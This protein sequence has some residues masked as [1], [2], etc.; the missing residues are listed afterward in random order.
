MRFFPEHVADA[1]F[2]AHEHLFSKEYDRPET[3]LHTGAFSAV[4]VTPGDDFVLKATVCPVNAAYLLKL[5]CIKVE[6]YDDEDACVELRQGSE[7]RAHLP[8]YWLEMPKGQVVVEAVHQKRAQAL[9]TCLNDMAKIAR[10]DA[11]KVVPLLSWLLDNNKEGILQEVLPYWPLGSWE[12]RT[13]EGVASQE[14]LSLPSGFCHAVKNLKQ[15][16]QRV[17]NLQLSVAQRLVLL[18]CYSTAQ[19]LGTQENCILD[20]VHPGNLLSLPA[21]M[22]SSEVR[23]LCLPT[24]SYLFLPHDPMLNKLVF[25]TIKDCDQMYLM[26]QEQAELVRL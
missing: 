21:T 9:A 15:L 8:V 16:K 18:Q 19:E 14:L 22:F 6:H 3:V 20:A 25:K 17:Q 7:V 1:L 24:E 10:S 26:P 2:S 23:S 12:H 13:V 5:P 11:S 4:W